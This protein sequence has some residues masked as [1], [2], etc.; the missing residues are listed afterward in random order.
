MHRRSHAQEVNEVEQTEQLDGVVGLL[1]M[2]ARLAQGL[3]SL[4]GFLR[5]WRQGGRIHRLVDAGQEGGPWPQE[6][7]GL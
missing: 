4:Q 5:E 1:V 7:L 6:V 2:C 3:Q